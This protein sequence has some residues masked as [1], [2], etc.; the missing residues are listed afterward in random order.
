MKTL[1]RDDTGHGVEYVTKAC[2]LEAQ[3]ARAAL[4]PV[5]YVSRQQLDRAIAG[6][7][8]GFKRKVESEFGAFFPVR[9]SPGG[10]FTEPLYAGRVALD[11]PSMRALV[12][13]LALAID[14]DANLER[15][16]EA[17]AFQIDMARALLR[18][19]GIQA[20]APTG[21]EP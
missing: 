13:R 4:V 12:S 2:A 14:P 5:L 8:P 1:T 21:I 19:F 15:F 11:T 9:I 7:H 6:R 3:N 20:V 16:P 10:Q 17:L 18:E